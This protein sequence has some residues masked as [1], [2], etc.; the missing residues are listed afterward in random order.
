VLST[1]LNKL[2]NNF[3]LPS[4]MIWG[5]ETISMNLSSMELLEIF[6]RI[7]KNRFGSPLEKV[8]ALLAHTIKYPA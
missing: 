3:S 4:G 8:P 2:I 1:D 7:D 5:F 6:V